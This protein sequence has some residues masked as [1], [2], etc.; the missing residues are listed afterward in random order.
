M[1]RAKDIIA[2]MAIARRV[3][4]LQVEHPGFVAAD[5]SNDNGRPCPHV[6]LKAEEFFEQFNDR[7][8]EY[9]EHEGTDGQKVRWVEGWIQ[10]VKF[11]AVLL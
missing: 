2:M 3:L 9:K 10:N 8:Y 11:T 5:T 4:E 7:E 1:I 6:Q